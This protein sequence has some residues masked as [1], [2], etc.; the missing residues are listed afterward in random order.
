MNELLSWTSL[1]NLHPAL[2]H[3]PIALVPMAILADVLRLIFRRQEWLD[4]AATG[5]YIAAALGALAALWAG[6]QAA[7]GL[8]AVPAEEWLL[9]GLVELLAIISSAVL[10]HVALRSVQATSS[11]LADIRARAVGASACTSESVVAYLISTS[12]P[13]SRRDRIRCRMGLPGK[14]INRKGDL[15][16][17]ANDW[18]SCKPSSCR[19][20]GDRSHHRSRQRYERHQ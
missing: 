11:H 4:R 2:V 15:H 5:L 16:A 7:D 13:T 19:H 12:V 6:E 17:Q 3:F 14:G 1:P 18:R 20:S 9:M 10:I 8:V